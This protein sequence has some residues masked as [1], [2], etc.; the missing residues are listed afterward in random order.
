M[1]FSLPN[2]TKVG[3]GFS[4]NWGS[5]VLRSEKY[6]ALSHVNQV[7]DNTVNNVAFHVSFTVTVCGKARTEY[8]V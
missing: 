8:S 3:Y 2:R 1:T 4:P 5:K 7:G 6:S